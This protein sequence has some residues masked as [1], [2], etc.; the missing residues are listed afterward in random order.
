MLHGVGLRNAASQLVNEGFS[1]LYRGIGPPL[2]QK[3]ISTSLMFGTYDAI[4]KPL[5]ESNLNTRLA[6][7]IAALVAGSAEA[8]LT[9]FERVQT[10]LQD[11][12]YNKKFIN[13]RHAIKVISTDYSVSEFYRGLTPILLRNGP[14]NISF[15]LL[16]E[17]ASSYI[18]I[19]PG[20]WTGY[21]VF[22]EFLTGAF[23]GALNS[24]LF[25]P[26]N[27]LKVHMQSNLGGPFKN[28]IQAASEIY[29]ERGN[30]VSYFYRGVHMNY[31]RAFV[32]WGVINVAYENLKYCLKKN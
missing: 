10:L 23:I 31:T 28:I 14:A 4:Q 6:K 32:S 7:V 27:V 29:R 24:A 1:T 19:S 30:R 5:L 3:T 25:Y 17:A 8:T 11:N 20:T 22:K 2:L 9:P 21:K 18:V 16:R 13:M 15:F 12:H 26:C